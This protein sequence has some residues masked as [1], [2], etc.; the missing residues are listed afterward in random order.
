VREHGVRRNS[1][2]FADF[3][4]ESWYPCLRAVLASGE[5][6]ERAEDLLAEAFAKAW[7]SWPQ[8]RDH[9]SP[10]A[11]VVRTAL[12]TRVSWWRRSWR[13]F[14]LADHD[15]A[16]PGDFADLIDVDLLAAIRRLP[17]R[18][19]QIVALRILAD[20]DTETTSRRLGIAPGTVRVHLSRAIHTLRREILPDDDNTEP[21]CTNTTT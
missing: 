2:E 12:N 19:R 20:L 6:L 17:I 8:L 9:P 3:Y 7:V 11:W 4:Q 16:L 13:E 15:L 18:Q 21:R 10:R 14:P 1:D 5:D